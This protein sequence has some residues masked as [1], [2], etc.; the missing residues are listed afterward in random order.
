MSDRFGL[1]Q[2]S[3]KHVAERWRNSYFCRGHWSDVRGECADVIYGKLKALGD[4]PEP[5]AVDAIIGN[6][7]WTH[8][9]CSACGNEVS[10]A[11]IFTNNGGM[12]ETVSL[13]ADCIKGICDV[14]DIE[15]YERSELARLKAKY[16]GKE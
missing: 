4:D 15:A 9:N 10:R 12:G 13:C 5:D 16:E 7:S 11:L 6:T 8:A 1:F 2:R 14:F 3:G